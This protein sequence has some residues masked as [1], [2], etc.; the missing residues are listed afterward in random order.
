MVRVQVGR[1]G[2]AKFARE[3]SG[4]TEGHARAWLLNIPKGMGWDNQ[5]TGTLA[6]VFSLTGSAAR[7]L[8]A[9]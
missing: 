2:C 8:M 5:L 3:S 4:A 7:H 6:F 1:E 9:T